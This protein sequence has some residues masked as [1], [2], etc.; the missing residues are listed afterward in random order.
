MSAI[1]EKLK[2]EL[3]DLSVKERAHVAD[4]LLHSLDGRPDADAEAAWDV[5]LE[6]RAGMIRSGTATGEPAE[7][8][9]GDLR[10]RFV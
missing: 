2:S 9:L 7:K 5:E 1:V 8:V 6:R 3:A 10:K 4:F